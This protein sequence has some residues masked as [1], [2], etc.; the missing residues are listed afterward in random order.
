MNPV[1]QRLPVH[2]AV[3]C[4]LAPTS[5]FQNRRQRQKTANLCP[6]QAP[7]RMISEVIGR[8]V[9]SRDLN[10]YAHPDLRPPNPDAPH[11]TRYLA[12]AESPKQRAGSTRVGISGFGSA[13]AGNRDRRL[14]FSRL[15]GVSVRQNLGILVTRTLRARNSARTESLNKVPENE[16]RTRRSAV[17]LS[18]GADGTGTGLVGVRGF[19]PPAPS[20]RISRSYPK[21]MIYKGFRTTW[22]GQFDQARPSESLKNSTLSLALLRAGVLDDRVNIVPIGWL[23]WRKTRR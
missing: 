16:R 18:I 9:R 5:A 14:P 2:A 8:V 22:M 11:R 19:E 7:A 1:T 3:C 4:S 20:S 21:C 10:S 12:P 13:D 15:S 17:A 6:V 23:L